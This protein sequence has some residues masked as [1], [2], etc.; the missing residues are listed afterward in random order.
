MA[1]SCSDS[2]FDWMDVVTGLLRPKSSRPDFS[3]RIVL[4]VLRL[5]ASL[6][7]RPSTGKWRWTIR[8]LARPRAEAEKLAWSCSVGCGVVVLG[9]W[10][11][12]QLPEIVVVVGLVL[13]R[14]ASGA[15]ITLKALSKGAIIP[16]KELGMSVD[17]LW[18]AVG[19]SLL[20]GPVA[21]D[22]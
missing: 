20:V 19:V 17:M 8:S 3:A 2:V 14:Y 11:E 13:Y 21:C 6:K 4:L 12:A 15:W 18:P 7:I 16:T 10:T 9:F 5:D 1:L 22:S